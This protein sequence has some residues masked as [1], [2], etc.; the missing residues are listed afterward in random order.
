MEILKIEGE[1]GW[2]IKIL[3]SCETVDQM[4][5]SQNVFKNFIKK[6]DKTISQERK[7]RLQDNFA[8]LMWVQSSKIKKKLVK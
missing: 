2:V 4:R 3:E 7:I 8:K 6:W 1:Y 5:V